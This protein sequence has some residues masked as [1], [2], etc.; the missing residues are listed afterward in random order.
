[1][2]CESRREVIVWFRS[3][4]GY[5]SSLACRWSFNGSSAHPIWR[6][7]LRHCDQAILGDTVIHCRMNAWMTPSPSSMCWVHRPSFVPDQRWL[8]KCSARLALEAVVLYLLPAESDPAAP[9]HGQAVEAGSFWPEESFWDFGWI[10]GHVD[11][12]KQN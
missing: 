1:M 8:S 5:G 2:G 3:N 7:G 9:R 12:T 6:S 11:Q 10:W 4:D